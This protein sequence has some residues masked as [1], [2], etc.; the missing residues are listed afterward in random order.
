MLSS[1]YAQVTRELR[2]SSIVAFEPFLL[3]LFPPQNDSAKTRYLFYRLVKK[4]WRFFVLVSL[5]K[6]TVDMILLDYASTETSQVKLFFS[7][8]SEK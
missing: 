6:N 2:Q 8:K 1:E 5:D 7:K 4:L 3:P